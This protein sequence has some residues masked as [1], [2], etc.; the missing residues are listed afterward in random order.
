MNGYYPGSDAP[1]RQSMADALQAGHHLLLAHGKAVPV[2]RANSPQA[3]VGMAL[4]LAPV[5]PL[6]PADVEAARRFDGYRHRWFLDPLFKGSYPEDMLALY[7]S[8]HNE[9]LLP[10]SAADDLRVMSTPTDYLG[11]NY[12]LPEYVKQDPTGFLGMASA[13]TEIEV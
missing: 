12:Y 7:H 6:T 5:R 11:L 10:R 1:G 3:E 9:N 4:G 2:I 13:N 8:Y